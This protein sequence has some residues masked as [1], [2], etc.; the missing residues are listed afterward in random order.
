MPADARVAV[1][2]VGV[3]APGATGADSLRD[4]LRSGRSSTSEI[5]R[6]ST[7]GFR[8]HRGALVRG[9][10]PRQFI[11]AAKSRRMNQLSRFGVASAR[12]ALD[13]AG[14]SG[15]I[16]QRGDAGVAI[17]TMFGPV[18][19]SVRYLTEYRRR[20][21]S[22]AP[23]QLFAESVANA[24]G[25]HIAIENGLRGFNLT[26]TQRE[27]SALTALAYAA[28][29]IAKGSVPAALAGGVEEVTEV[30]YGVLERIGALSGEDRHGAEEARPL[31]ASRNG[32]VFGE[33]GM[34][35][36]LVGDPAE[37]SPWGWVAGFAVGRDRTATISDWGEDPRA[38]ASVMARA[39]EDAN[40]EISEIDAVFVSANGSRA[41]D[42]LEARAL[43]AL[44]GEACPPVVATKGVFGEYAA[45]GGV[46]IAS[47]L[48][49]LRH[50]E[51]YPSVGFSSAEPGLE[52]P[53]TERYTV[54]PLRTVLIN[55]V[56]A[57]GGIISAVFSRDRA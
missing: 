36:L 46:Q 54:R 16:G 1:V 17:G 45:G 25:S 42:A 29:Q 13:D 51:L 43:R 53:V 7:S 31:D 39:I 56:S 12:L 30:T 52:L 11:A 14:G 49:A 48:L 40:L 20:G 34:M 38:V 28:M 37:G 47:A 57:G 4:L 44:F 21:P 41:G 5:D 3:I 2:G 18:E 27:G 26:F 15:Q 22:L 6:F 24:P 19:T 33:G 23:P 8:S 50:G 55:A 9:F 10:D 35:A 32:F